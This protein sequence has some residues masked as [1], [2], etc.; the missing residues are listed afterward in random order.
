[1]AFSDEDNFFQSGAMSPNLG[2][3]FFLSLAFCIAFWTKIDKAVTF[4]V[5]FAF[6]NQSSLSFF[7]SF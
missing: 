1:L 3:S 2:I 7:L 6:S 5:F 4:L